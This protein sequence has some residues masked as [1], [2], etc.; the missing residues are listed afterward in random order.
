[1][2]TPT[3]IK[4]AQDGC[5]PERFTGSLLASGR[6]ITPKGNL[7][8]R[9]HELDI[10]A[11]VR[12]DIV[13]H[14]RFRTSLGRESPVTYCRRF[15]DLEE[16]ADWADEHP[17]ERDAGG[18]PP[19]EEYRERQDVLDEDLRQGWSALVGRVLYQAEE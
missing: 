15:G 11:D 6:S 13:A 1:M 7:A 8:S 2:T 19:G 17:I 4:L 5:R 3:R 12:G 10:Y 16:F 18:Y 9:W 14:I